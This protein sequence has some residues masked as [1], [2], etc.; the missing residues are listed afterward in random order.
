M[1]ACLLAEGR[2]VLTNVPRITDVDIMAEVLGAMGVDVH[3]AD[4]APDELVIDHPGRR[5]SPR[6]PTSWWRRCGPRWWCSGRC[7]ARCGRARVSM[8]GGDDFGPRPI[9]MHLHALESLGARVRHR[10]TATWRAGSSPPWPAR[11]AWWA[12]GWCSSTRATPAPTTC[13]WPR[14]WP[15]ARPSSRTRPASPRCATWPTSSTPWGPGSPA[16][17]RRASRSKGSTSSQPATH[18]VIPDRLVVATFLVA[19]GLAGGEVVVEDGRPDH[20]DMLIRKLTAI[21]I[22]ITQEPDGLRAARDRR[23]RAAVGR[24]WPPCPTRGSPPTTSR[25]WSPC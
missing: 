14:S 4:R 18:A 17:A 19:A 12:T 7:S 13:S 3:A 25:C 10:P 20:M 21:G 8:P 2:H 24:T 15:R 6:P 16:P 1:A 11:P 22:D 5:R 23:R 9:D